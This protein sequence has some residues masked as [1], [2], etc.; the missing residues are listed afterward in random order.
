[1]PALVLR[2]PSTFEDG[3]ASIRRELNVP[4][5]FPAEVLD[6]AASARVDLDDGSRTDARHIPFVAIDPP[7][8]TDLD[9]A[10]A[11]ERLDDGYRVRYAIADVAPF[12]RPGGALDTEARH[13][14][15][16]LYS[17]DGRT[18]LHPP[19][20]SEDRASLLA[21]TD[22]PALLWT[23]DLDGGGAPVGWN[24]ERAIVNVRA[25]ISYVTAQAHI[26]AGTEPSAAPGPGAGTGNL[27]LL[28]DIGRLRQAQEEQ[29]GGI[30][31]NLPAQEIV[32]HDNSYT[33]E[34][35]TTLPVEGWNAQISLLT[36][37]VAAR[38]MTAAGV[39]ILRTL[40]T[41]FERAI[42]RL[43]LTAQA[44]GLDWP[45]EVPYPT[46]VRGLTP[47]SAP[48]NTFLVQA[49]RTLRGAGYVGFNGE[50][51]ANPEH[52]AIASVYAHVTAPLRRLV[53]RFGNE[54]LL[55]LLAEQEPPA[56]AIEALDELPSLMGQ[57]RQR[58]SAL[59]R[60]MLDFA[61]AVVLE[62]HVGAVFDGFVVDLDKARERARIQIGEPAIVAPV[63]AN[64]RRLGETVK[65]ELTS[66]DVQ[67]REVN[68]DVVDRKAI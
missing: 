56:W 39:G 40:P 38:T 25:A 62:R 30:S 52:G 65:L 66:V 10:F 24:L 60:S 14:G 34:F 57:A 36:G 17:P 49:T 45:Q 48:C 13:R 16:T 7:G 3:F 22:K 35:D 61:E 21:D 55:A 54:I 50:V 8:A 42:S 43:R 18:P 67:E 28:R 5:A 20:I 46:F 32:E 19:T 9:Q 58:E 4:E 12:L 29:R 31:L 37:I 53:D 47:N 44:L 64:G 27:A 51:P 15:S 41:P 1:M 63:D 68:F 59:E 26:D 6:E 11:A 23:I 2:A 33:L